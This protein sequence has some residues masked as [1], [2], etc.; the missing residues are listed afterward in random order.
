MSKYWK[1][2]EIL[3]K[4]KSFKDDNSLFLTENPKIIPENKN[5]KMVVYN[6]ENLEEIFFDEIA[7][8]FN[9]NYSNSDKSKF[10]I[11]ENII[12]NYLNINSEIMTIY[13]GK[14]V[15]EAFAFYFP[16]CVQT[17]LKINNPKYSPF[18]EQLQ[19]ENSIIFG[20][21]TFLSVDGNIRNKG[22]GMNLIQ[23]SLKTFYKKGG[24]AAYFINKISR[25]ENSIMFNNWYFP[26]NLE[27]LDRIKYLYPRNYKS[28][29]RLN[30]IK[31]KIKAVNENNIIKAYDFYI[32]IVKDKK[33][34]FKTNFYLWKKWIKTFP[35]YLVF[36][37]E[38]V[39]G[40]FSFHR[41]KRFYENFEETLNICD[42]ILCI[43]E[44]PMTLK[45]SFIQ[46]KNEFDIVYTRELGDLNEYI[47]RKSNAQISGS[48]YINFF[49]TRIKLEKSEFYAPIF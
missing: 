36:D 48:A 44:Q 14:L 30:P 12:K 16:V 46:A 41:V 4:D 19:S 28:L 15:G 21:Y 39:I 29:F 9:S 1:N 47:L 24:L 32:N 5:Y 40:I 7:L 2:L 42:L 8:F 13:K 20:C 45:S 23:E 22:L 26:L 18:L 37:N 3:R 27:K 17:E 34:Y 31:E 35:T 49:N 10:I 6:K 11:D 38:D 43:G 25:C 33:F